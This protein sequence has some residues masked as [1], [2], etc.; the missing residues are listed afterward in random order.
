MRPSV[1][2]LESSRQSASV[3]RCRRLYRIPDHTLAGEGTTFEKL[4]PAGT[5]IIITYMIWT[6]VNFQGSEIV[7]LSAAEIRIRRPT[8]HSPAE[9][10]HSGSS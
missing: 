4:F 7:G 2:S 10:L 5:F 6:L 1:S 9:E 3:Y 8:F